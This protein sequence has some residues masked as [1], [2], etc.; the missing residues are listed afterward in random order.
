VA[1]P[2]LW[3]LAQAWFGVDRR[4]PEWRRPTPEEAEAIFASAGLKGPF[5]GLR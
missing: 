2:K 5:W 3:E 4:A 1:A